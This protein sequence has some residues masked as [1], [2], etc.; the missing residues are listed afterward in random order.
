MI[1]C[2]IR[3]IL[4]QTN[5]IKSLLTSNDNSSPS[6]PSNGDITNKK[7]KNISNKFELTE[8]QM[9]ACARDLLVLCNR[10]QSGGDTYYCLE[11]LFMNKDN[12]LCI[13]TPYAA[14]ADPLDIVI[15]IVESNCKVPV[16]T[17]KKINHRYN[18]EINSE[19]K[20]ININKIFSNITTPI[21]EDQYNGD[22][23]CYSCYSE[24]YSSCMTETDD[25]SNE[26]STPKTS[27]NKIDY[28]SI[29][30]GKVNNIK[31]HSLNN[32]TEDPCEICDSFLFVEYR[33]RRQ[34]MSLDL[35]DQG[36]ICLTS[37]PTMNNSPTSIHSSP[38]NGS[39]RYNNNNNNNNNRSEEKNPPPLAR[40][41]WDNGSVISDLT[42]DSSLIAN[43]S[44]LIQSSP[45][46]IKSQKS[47]TAI[48]TKE[49]TFSSSNWKPGERKFQKLKRDD[50][51]NEKKIKNKPNNKPTNVAFVNSNNSNRSINNTINT[52]TTTESIDND[53]LTVYSISN[54]DLKGYLKPLY[55]SNNDVSK[56]TSP[57]THDITVTPPKSP[58]LNKSE[59]NHSSVSNMSIN[60]P[61]SVDSKI[62]SSLNLK[63][64]P[65]TINNSDSISL[66]SRII[67]TPTRLRNKFK[68][69]NKTP[70][71]TLPYN[72]EQHNNNNNYI[73]PFSL[74]KSN[75]KYN[76]K[77]SPDTDSPNKINTSMCI[78]IKVNSTSKYRVCDSNPQGDDRDNIAVVSGKFQQYFFIKSNCNGKLSLSNR[79]VTINTE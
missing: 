17:K 31:K 52:A 65:V 9:L 57:I 63:S 3:H 13:L 39:N 49:T 78:R 12:G 74:P 11:S 55:D 27:N 21:E 72:K 26:E 66:L 4:E 58:I 59:N 25:Y 35:D 76:F 24:P 28:D 43:K 45:I 41:L 42:L 44:N 33:R 75:S 5:N 50:R 10:T 68:S 23:E 60:I 53:D 6:T 20:K 36:T 56:N 14:E 8:G 1:G 79:I 38:P 64:S 61:S 77:P 37:P 73:T 69:G 54:S 32:C 46:R 19:E 15:D 51:V 30:N 71:E 67:A 48:V 70:I 40:K 16:S 18:H 47:P 29:I 22:N 2:I 7:K 34:Q 62:N